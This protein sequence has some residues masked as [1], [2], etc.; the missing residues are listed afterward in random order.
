MPG[1]QAGTES[2]FELVEGSGIVF[3]DLGDREADLRQ[4]KTVLAARSVVVVND[5]ELSVRKS[6]V[7]ARFAA[8]NFLCVR[9]ADF[10]G[11]TL[12]RLVRQ[13]LSSLDARVC[14]TVGLEAGVPWRTARRP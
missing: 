14:R 11:F 1:R 10:R 5:R 13:L 2:D 12:D 7:L 4:A 3:R 8:A 9:N 6:V